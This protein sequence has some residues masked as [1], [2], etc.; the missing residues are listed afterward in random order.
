M[1]E[2][3]SCILTRVDTSFLSESY[4][5][6]YLSS[7]CLFWCRYWRPVGLRYVGLSVWAR[8][9]VLSVNLSVLMLVAYYFC[10]VCEKVRIVYLYI[11]V[12]VCAKVWVCTKCILVPVR[13]QQDYLPQS[14]STLTFSTGS[15]IESNTHWLAGLF[16]QRAPGIP[17]PSSLSSRCRPCLAF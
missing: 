14:F 6:N 13:S 5:T 15:L 8:D 4:W 3:P 12:H 2:G 1:N 17:S 16:G 10:V 7:L 9:C 11:Y